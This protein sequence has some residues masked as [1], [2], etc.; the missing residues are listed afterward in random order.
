MA[1][2][3]SSVKAENT[4]PVVFHA[5]ASPAVILS[6]VVQRPRKTADLRIRKPQRRAVCIFTLR[7][8]VQHQH[9]QSFAA[10]RARIFQH[11]LI[12]DGVAERRIGAASDHEMY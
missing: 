5:G 7:I 9:H 3:W 6:L 10:A 8:V 4:L 2:T 11:L 1:S 12:A